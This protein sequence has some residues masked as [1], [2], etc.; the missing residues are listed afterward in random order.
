MEENKNL[1]SEVKLLQGKIKYM[2]SEK[3]RN[4][5]LIFG[6]K[7]KQHENLI[8]EVK[9]IVETHTEAKIEHYEINKAYRLGVKG[10][11]TRPILVSFTTKWKRDEVMRKKNKLTTDIYFKDDLSKETLEKRRELLPKLKEERDK[12]KL[13]YIRGDKLIVRE[14]KE[15]TR[16]KRKRS[17]LESPNTSPSQEP[18]PAPKKINKT[19]MFDYMARGRSASLSEKSKN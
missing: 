8:N 14:P 5:L 10:E 16:D 12:G 15:D 17:S 1:K 6:A 7:E 2:D 11:K 9:T 3:R 4:N 18:T 13:A 19:N